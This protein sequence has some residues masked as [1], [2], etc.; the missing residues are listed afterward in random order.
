MWL[1]RVMRLIGGTPIPP[2]NHGARIHQ[3]IPAAG[4]GYGPAGRTWV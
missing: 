4:A 3:A 2:I 1:I